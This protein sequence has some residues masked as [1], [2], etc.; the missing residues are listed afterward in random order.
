MLAHW[1]PVLKKEGRE[2]EYTFDAHEERTG[3]PTLLRRLDELV[4]AYDD[5]QTKQSSLED[6]FV[7][8]VTETRMNT[9]A[10]NAIYRF[11]MA[12]FRRTLWQS[13]ITP[14]ITTSLY[15]VVF[16][17]AIGRRMAEIGGVPYGAFIVPGLIM[18]SVFTESLNNSSFGIYL[19]K[20]TGTIYELLSAPISPLEIVIAYVG[21]AA[22]KSVILGPR[23]LR[24][25]QSL[26]ADPRGPSGVDDAL[27]S[28][29]RRRPSASSVSSWA[30]G[31]RASSSS[32]SSR[33]W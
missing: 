10:V 17:A 30:S 9:Y 1:K 20:F 4:I 31:R 23:D 11:E 29:S 6:I 33:C 27:S 7:S 25:R 26:R 8:L 16:G 19:P 2:L 12:R 28:C 13:L 24:H 5:L 32:R 15:F 21:A 18:L 22:T 3:I 14:V